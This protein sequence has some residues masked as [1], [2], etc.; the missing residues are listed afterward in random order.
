VSNPEGV[1]RQHPVKLNI[2]DHEI[3]FLAV[4]SSGPGGQHVNKTSSA[5][6]LLW[7]PQHSSVLTPFQKHLV[8]TKLAGRLDKDLNLQIRCEEQRDQLSNKKGA[9]AK[10]IALVEAAL[11]V[12]KVRRKTKPTKGSQRR[13]R[14]AKTKHGEKK[15]NRQRMTD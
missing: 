1:Q 4:R 15:R 14:E 6:I 2:P 9:V 5:V 13:R 8:L 11:T 3:S 12:P 7:S 10:L